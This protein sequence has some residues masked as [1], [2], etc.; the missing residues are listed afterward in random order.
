MQWSS[1]CG[2]PWTTRAPSGQWGSALSGGSSSCSLSWCCSGSSVERADRASVQNDR[3]SAERIEENGRR[4]HFQQEHGSSPTGLASRAH[5][6]SF[7]RADQI[8]SRRPSAPFPLFFPC[9][10]SLSR[11]SC[12]LCLRASSVFSAV[13][14]RRL[15][16]LFMA[17]V[18]VD[19]RESP[20]F[21][22]VFDDLFPGHSRSALI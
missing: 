21:G 20:S 8:L 16:V 19:L 7:L 12:S 22:P 6:S 2:R 9:R 10:L 15:P 18:A 4:G 11:A 13:G 3:C 14:V 1:R 5:F 17:D